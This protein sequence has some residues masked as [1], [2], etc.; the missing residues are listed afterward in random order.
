MMKTKHYFNLLLLLT[1]MIDVDAQ[2][3]IGD[4]TLPQSYSLLEIST[5]VSKGGLRLPQLTT[6]QRDSITNVAGF[7]T[8]VKARGLTFY[9]TTT[10]CYEYWN[11]VK[12]VSLCQGQANVTFTDKNGNEVDPGKDPFPPEGGDIGPFAPHDS[13]DCVGQ[14]PAYNFLV[15]TGQSYAHVEIVNPST[16]E[17][18]IRMDA[19]PMAIS[20]SAIV[21]VVNNCTNE[22]KE[23]LFTQQGDDSDCNTSATVPAIKSYN[24]SGSTALCVSGAVYLYLDGNP[25]TGNYIW[26]LN[27]QEVAQGYTYTAT[28]PGR[29]VVYGDKIGCT[30]KSEI[31]VTPGSNTAP[32]PVEFIV[33]GN[34]GVACGTGGTVELVVTRPVSGKI[35][36]YKDG[37]LMDDT[38][39]YN[40][41]NKIDA[42]AG[43]WR[44]VVVDSAC[45]SLPAGPVSVSEADGSNTIPK[46]VMK[47]NGVVATTGGYKLCQN[48]SMYLEVDSYDNTHT[49]TW[50]IDN[51]PIGTGTGI[52]HAVPSYPEFVLRLRATGTGCA[53]EALSLEKVTP[54]V[55]PAPPVITVNTGNVLC[56]GQAT[57]FAGGNGASAFRWFKNGV[58]ITGQTA[59]SITVTESAAYTVTAIDSG[60]CTGLMSGA[61][62][63]TASDFATVSWVHHPAN[64]NI[65]DSKTFAVSVD[66]PEG[67]VYTWSVANGNGATITT[68]QGTASIIVNFPQE[69]TATVSC[70]V[71]TAC[72][73]AIGSPVSQA[74][75][76]AKACTPP[77]IMKTSNQNPKIKTKHTTTLSVTVTGTSPRYQWYKGATGSGTAVSGATSASYMV[78]SAE[79]A[80]V[81]TLQYYCQVINDCGNVT[82]PQFTV[83]V[84]FDPATITVGTG[85]FAGRTCFDIAKGNDDAN[86]CGPVAGRAKHKADFS[87]RAEQTVGAVAPF[88]GVQVYT[89]TPSG[90]VSRVRFDYVEVS[91]VE[92]V[93]SIVPRSATYATTDNINTPCQ[94]VVYYNRN[95]NTTLAGLSR[96]NGYKLKLYAIYNSKSSYTAAADDRRLEMTVGLQDC[97]CCGAATATLA[98]GAPD[99]WLSFMCHNLGANGDLDPFLWNNSAGNANVFDNGFADA[100]AGNY[101]DI[102]GW[103]FQWGRPA[104]GH[105]LRSSSRLTNNHPSMSTYNP[106]YF[107]NFYINAVDWISNWTSAAARKRWGDGSIGVSS[108]YDQPKGAFDPC[109]PG[110]KVPSQKQWASIFRPD[111]S[112]TEAP[113]SAT[114]NTWVWTGNG[115]KVGDALYLPAAGYRNNG[116][117]GI[118]NV[119]SYGS[120]WSSNYLSLSS[121]LSYHL[122]F[123]SGSINAVNANDRSY[124]YSVRCVAE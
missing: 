76:V 70:T 75:T 61:K 112:K 63:I 108:T 22:Y 3:T 88:S 89:F 2:V 62:T 57:L 9:N 95:L 47:V 82:S 66:Y 30:N 15:M 13:P 85:S 71:T 46:P 8:A 39:K 114:A 97:A 52:Y 6:A 73:N 107:N 123:D 18:R 68:G 121:S 7:K 113:G 99:G 80:T 115:Y 50:Y 4:E 40:N 69:A 84:S 59:S 101:K 1:A 122:S 106:A 12:W 36:W 100:T 14:M 109:P 35:Y 38:A 87:L 110:W 26:T 94:V 44:A 72:G 16:G 48:G 5:D 24:P 19:N 67:V 58:E 37:K 124:G 41:K 116:N 93:D 119:G 11:N 92:I 96:A 51:T 56:G 64:A 120:Y 104:D 91:G 81:G 21:R 23:F 102:K 49:Y 79:T 111:A 103:M 90:T 78:P 98:G 54:S 117:A 31:V 34:N 65:G 77:V 60:G 53:S 33:V 29:Y 74:V 86:S 25:S 28:V 20:R 42:G 43:S 45:V 32:S 10:N 118:Y 55:A 83:S 17:F 105:Q 27:G